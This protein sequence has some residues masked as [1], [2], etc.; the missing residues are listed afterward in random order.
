MLIGVVSDTHNN[1][2]NTE[3]IIS[4]FNENCV[5]MVL[6]TGDIT[7]KATLKR[8]SR[9]NSSLRGVFGNNDRC[10]SGLLEISSKYN[11]DFKDPPYTFSV[12]QKNIAI[13]HEPDGIEEFLKKNKDIDIVVHGHTHRYREE[14]IEE[15]IVFNPGESAGM[16]KGSNALGIIDLI[17]MTFKRIFF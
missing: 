4:L 11:F 7:N 15:T 6:H 14:V 2:K 5:D 1:A 16:I 10:E 3:N 13:F 9:L 17:N 12:M 8:F